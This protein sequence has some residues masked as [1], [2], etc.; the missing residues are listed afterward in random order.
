[1]LGEHYLQLDGQGSPTNTVTFDQKSEGGA[2]SLHSYLEEGHAVEEET[3]RANILRYKVC[4][5]CLRDRKESSIVK[6]V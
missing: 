3:A 4:S 1:M 2:G 6:T 5:K